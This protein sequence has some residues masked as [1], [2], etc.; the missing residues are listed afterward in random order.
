MPS[1]AR[2]QRLEE[3]PGHARVAE[4]RREGTAPAASVD[5][6]TTSAWSVWASAIDGGLDRREGRIEAGFDADR[7][8]LVLGAGWQP[9]PTISLDAGWQTF[10]ERLDYTASDGRLDA[11]VDGP[12]L[13]AAWMPTAAWRLEAQADW[14]EGRLESRRPV[15]YALPGGE[16]IDS[17]ARAQTHTRR[18]GAA[19]AVRRSD[20]LGAIAIDSG[21]GLDDSRVRIA[22]YA[23]SGGAG[24]ALAVP[25]RE[26]RSRRIQL[27]T[28]VSAALSRPSGVWVPSL[29]LTAVREL[30]D[31]SRTLA[32]R[33]VDDAIGTPV[34]FATEEPD[35]QW[36]DIALGL[37]W[38]RP[39]GH[40]FFVEG[41]HRLGHRFL[42]EQQLG[43]GFRIER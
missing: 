11:R 30:D 41:R 26:R 38:V 22:P 21:L 10:R 17:E 35:D 3:L 43:V 32:V 18:R 12:L 27:D 7:T 29:R 33:F 31:P 2:A 8:G 14:S 23:E 1:A 34:R 28:L 37:S 25:A 16:S 24:W 36:F 39:G 4:T 13:V 42:R 19:I 15:R 5:S 40:S 20:S 9:A 6:G